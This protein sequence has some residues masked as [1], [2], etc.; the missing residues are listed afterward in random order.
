MLSETK[1]KTLK[2]EIN[3]CSREELIWFKGYL[4]GLL[5]QSDNG[6]QTQAPVIEQV[7]IRPSIIYGTETGNSKKLAFQLLSTLKKSKI[8]AKSTDVSQFSVEKL[9]KEDFIIIIISTQGDGDLPTNAVEFFEALKRKAPNLEKTKFA[10]FGLGDTSYPFFCKAAE[11][12]DLLLEQLGA[13]RVLPIKKADVEYSDLAEQWFSQLQEVLQSAGQ[14]PS[15]TSALSVIEPAVSSK[16]TLEGV[17]SHKVVLNDRGSN[18]ETYHIEIATND[19]LN[20]EPGDAVGFYPTNN[21]GELREIAALFQAEERYFELQNKNIRGL[22]AKSILSF[23]SYLK[24]SIEED[25][26]DLLDLLSKYGGSD[27]HLLSFEDLLNLLH[28]IVPRLYSISSSPEAH[29]E[30]LHITVCLDQFNSNGKDKLGLC[31]NYL[32]EL[33]LNT[34]IEFYIHKNQNFRLPAEDQNIIMIGPG[35]GIA[36]FRSFLAHRDA[37]GA[38]GKNWLFFGEQH[39]VSDF[40]YQTEIQEWIATGVLSKLDTAFSRD[41]KH[42]IYVQDRLKEN[43]SEVF[44][45]LEDGAYLYVCG[46]KSPM[47]IDVENTLVE[48]IS[49]FQNKGEEEARDYLEK[50]ELEGRYNKDVY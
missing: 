33:P 17:I 42:K 43:A 26:I 37:T 5:E 50:M 27:L 38:E 24:V 48:I 4:A 47:S 7:K 6:S 44:R 41:Q 39:F 18:K 20:Y 23:E 21:E 19:S 25:R 31:S 1:L 32:A 29:E 30:E 2:S 14:K 45:W 36:P 34:G 15:T 22:S 10:V 40:Y 16:R 35:T 13:Q 8:Q 9:E 46:Q 49:L 3:S 28:P 12:V 11:D